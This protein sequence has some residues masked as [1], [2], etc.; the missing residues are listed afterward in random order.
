MTKTDSLIGGGLLH[1]QQALEEALEGEVHFDRFTRAMHATDASVYQLLPLGVVAPRSRED[2]IRTVQLCQQHG[3][4]ITARGGGTSQAGQSIGNGISL[5]FS[6]HL[7]RVLDLNVD[8]R[9]VWV[10]PGVVLDELN[11]QLKPH[12]LQLPLDLST[13]SRATIGGMIANNS[14]GT[15]SIIYGK[16]IDYVEAMSVL[17][18]DGT[19]IEIGALTNDALEAKCAQQDLEGAI[20][21]TV[22]HLGIEHQ[23]EIDQRYPK[24]QR[25]VGGYNLDEF[26]PTQI[27]SERPFNLA[28]MMVGSEGTLG[29]TLAAKMR[30]VPLAKQKVLCA[31][32]FTDLLDAMSATPVILAHNPSAVELVDRLLLDATRGKIEFEPMRDFIQGDPDA[33]LLVEFYGESSDELPPRLDQL[34]AALADR[35]LGYYFHRAIAPAAQA[36][37]WSLRQAALGLTM[38]EIGDEKAISFVEDTAVPPAHLHD[39]IATFKRILAEHEI[40]AAFYAHASVGLLHV[41]PVVNMKTAEGVRKFASIANEVADLVLEYGG[42]LSGEHGDGLVRAPFQEK[43]FGPVLYQA[44][45]EVKAAFDPMALFN[46]GK[47]VHAPPLTD[48]LRYGNGYTQQE[49]ETAF[50]FSDFGGFQRA[51]EQCSGVGACR[52]TLTG[53]MCPSYMA[54]RNEMHS[55]RG[56]ANAL[57]LAISGQLDTSELAHEELLPVMDLCLECKACKS[58]CPTGVDM[59]RLKSEVLHQHHQQQGAALKDRLVANIEGISRWGSRFAPLANWALNLGITRQVNER[60]LGFDRRRGLPAF[61][62]HPFHANAQTTHH[63]TSPGSSETATVALFADTFNNFY[64]PD[65]LTAAMDVLQGLGATVEVP[66]FVCC[67]RPLISKGFLD[68][69]TKQARATMRALLPLAERGIPILFAEPSCYSAVVDDHPKLLR[70]Q[71]QADAQKVADAAK[72]LEE[73]VGPALQGHAVQA[74]PRRVLFHGHCH[75]KALVGVDPTVALLRAIPDCEVVALDSGCCGMAGSFGYTHYEIS[76][77]IG[78][79]RLFPALRNLPADTTV[80]SPGFSCRQQIKQFTGV[81]AESPLSLLATLLT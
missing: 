29:I 26:V 35:G 50:D 76:Q 13:A 43:I 81:H 36:R 56:R 3:V 67:G 32:H 78:E 46:P 19:V 9:V 47:I 71:E 5:D 21:R 24:I 27:S 4:S 54:T 2:L 59:A 15:R 20:Y 23:D 70:G 69:A 14:A 1:F 16:T 66:P 62:R 12:G 37:I 18:A 77:T 7:N 73:W 39:Y 31:I 68:A 42:A 53:T 57:R 40:S 34:E 65:Q 17:L 10:E 61:A 28:R 52:K 25:R 11:A 51:A 33:V 72:L 55:T 38:A 49:V 64:E 48:D 8:E 6:R 22:R 44:F 41:R 58:E 75:Q 79:Q 74:G 30:L 80:V 63:A 60:L 45:C